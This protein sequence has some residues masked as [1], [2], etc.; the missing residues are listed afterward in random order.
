VLPGPFLGDF[1]LLK[2]LDVFTWAPCGGSGPA[3]MAITTTGQVDNM[4]ARDQQGL[5]TVEQTDGLFKVIVNV[6][7]KRC[8]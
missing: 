7:W 6:Q 8:T 2:P 5:L 4:M 1:E 3:A